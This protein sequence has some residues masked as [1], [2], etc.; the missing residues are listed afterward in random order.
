VTNFPSCRLLVRASALKLFEPFATARQQVGR[1]VKVLWNMEREFSRNVVPETG[2]WSRPA[3]D[4]NN[5]RH[6]IIEI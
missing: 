1:P 4:Y 2:A 3:S 5:R 6:C